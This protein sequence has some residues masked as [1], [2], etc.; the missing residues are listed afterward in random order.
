MTLPIAGPASGGTNNEVTEGLNP[1]SPFE[2][3]KLLLTQRFMR[4][5]IFAGCLK[6]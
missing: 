5:V 1:N 6:V 3:N 4:T 2:L